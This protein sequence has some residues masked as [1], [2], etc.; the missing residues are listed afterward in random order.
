MLPLLLA[1]TLQSPTVNPPLLDLNL[2]PGEVQ[3]HTIQ[4][5]LPGETSVSMADVFFLADSTGSM[6][7]YIDQVQTDAAVILGTLLGD[8]NI[9]FHIGVGDYKDF[10]LDPV[11]NLYGFSLAQSITDD[12]AA[13]NGAINNW[14][15]LGGND[16]PEGQLY[17][18]DRI[19]NDPA[20]GW[21]PNSKRIIVYF[22]DAPGHDPVCSAISGLTYDI[23]EAS[24]IT[25]LQGAGAGGTTVIGISVGTGLNNPGNSDNYTPDCGESSFGS[26]QADRITD[27]TGGLVEVIGNSA[28]VTDAILDAIET[29]LSEV[30]VSLLP[31]GAISPYVTSVQPASQTVTLPEN[32]R[33]TICC[34]FVVTF[35]GECADDGSTAN[36]SGDLQLSLDAIPISTSVPTSLH[37]ELCPP[38][39]YE[40]LGCEEFDRTETLT[41]ADTLTLLTRAH[42]P[43]HVL[44]YAF[45]YAVDD[46]GAAIGFDGL[47][48]QQLVVDGITSLQH[49]I[50]AVDFRAQV[51]AGAPT[52]LD[53]D[54]ILDLNGA[55]YEAA[56]GEL[57]FP[58]FF[59]QSSFF[60]GYMIL[61][62]LS[63]GREFQTTADILIRNDNEEVFSTE[64][65]FGC[66]DRFYLQDISAAFGQQFLSTT[67]HDSEELY[68]APN[69][70][71]G[72]FS[73]KGSVASSGSHSIPDPA[74]YGV[75]V[76]RAVSVGGA[77]LPFEVC[78]R[79]GHLFPRGIFGDNEE[80]AATG[81]TDC[82]EDLSRRAPASLL[83]FP[84]FDN[85]NGVAT[86][87]T[88]TNTDTQAGTNVHFVYLGR[89]GN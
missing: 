50:N 56:P 83:L 66:W 88:V 84:E 11:W 79:S 38:P 58:R 68:G 86:V 61:I 60:D 89:Y 33:E 54:D 57:L 34:D 6:G 12:A 2:A 70:E 43:E 40:D 29:V 73:M 9:D 51:A 37:F 41:A 45:A 5:C 3:Q 72:W 77:D 80:L 46:D 39:F 22:G 42:N 26:G 21:R 7:D 64:H 24:L 75:Y 4:V 59:G 16:T 27:A 28:E 87:F 36:P 49:S 15:A 13:I 81:G 55:E 69:Y 10:P 8:P 74:I 82:S 85:R 17:A 19:V 18:L 53:A 47:I 14:A 71:T 25:D 52:D 76:D 78:K 30:D 63:G 67:D 48:G 44:G 31:T 35:Q 32:P 20:V 23:T 62:G 65:T 1:I